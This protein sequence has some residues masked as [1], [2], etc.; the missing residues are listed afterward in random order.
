MAITAIHVECEVALTRRV[1]AVADESSLQPAGVRC[2]VF[3]W[4]DFFWHSRVAGWSNLEKAD[5]AE[6]IKYSTPLSGWAIVAL[7]FS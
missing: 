2:H 1:L 6:W 7:K 4:R 5:K 3:V